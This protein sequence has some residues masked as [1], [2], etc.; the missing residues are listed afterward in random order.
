ME[1]AGRASVQARRTCNAQVGL[2]GGVH[3]EV[4][5]GEGRGGAARCSGSQSSRAGAGRWGG[6]TGEVRSAAA[7]EGEG[8]G[9]DLGVERRL[10]GRNG[11]AQVTKAAGGARRGLAE[12]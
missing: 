8:E 5:E 3:G 11:R 7:C 4:V 10:C 2:A 9:E 6:G 12:G 1:R